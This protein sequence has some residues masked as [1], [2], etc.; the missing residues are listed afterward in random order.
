MAF[1]DS[2]TKGFSSPSQIFANILKL[3]GPNAK[4]VGPGF[5]FNNKGLFFY[6]TIN[7]ATGHLV[8]SLA[9]AGGP[10][11]GVGNAFLAGVSV[12]DTGGSHQFVEVANGVITFGDNGSFTP[13]KFSAIGGDPTL[14]SGTNGAA[15]NPCGM[16][17]QSQNNSDSGTSPEIVSFAR[18]QIQNGFG[19]SE[20][21]RTMDPNNPNADEG[22]HALGFAGA[23]TQAAGRFACQYVLNA[24]PA[25]SALIMG[26]FHVGAAVVAG[27]AMTTATPGQY[28]PTPNGHDVSGWDVTA[29]IPVRFT[30]TTGGILQCSGPVA[31]IAIGDI[32]D[33]PPQIIY[34][35]T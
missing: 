4:I 33:I 13:G 12:Y 32:I 17:W 15:D 25:R 26:S 14:F 20:Y 6:N 3:V 22:P 29:S 34:L 10:N 31:G 16:T 30:Y 27:Q 2:Q 1:G 19:N 5:V 8:I 7:P 28:H 9:P 21:A 11:D 35:D 18:I 23:W 24:A